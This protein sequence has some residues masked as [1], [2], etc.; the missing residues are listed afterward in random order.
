MSR[1]EF[2]IG[3]YSKFVRP[4]FYEPVGHYPQR[5][6]DDYISRT[7]LAKADRLDESLP[8]LYSWLGTPVFAD[9][10]LM[11]QDSGTTLSLE[12]VLIEVRNKKNIVKTAVQGLTGTFKEFINTGDY[13]ITIR[14]GLFNINPFKYPKEAMD[15]MV[16]LCN[17]TDALYVQ[18]DFLN[19]FDI[20]NLVIEDYRF[21]QRAGNQ[22]NQ[23][24]ELKCVSDLPVQLQ[25]DQQ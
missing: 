12:T 2:L 22:S 17:A 23:L 19:L 20:F 21:I 1:V 16:K 4:V 18:S 24:F 15:N 13:D 5:Q 14:G 10:V 7:P 3:E 9:V 11:D 25:L 6:E 8:A